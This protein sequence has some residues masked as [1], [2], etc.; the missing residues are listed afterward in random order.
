VTRAADLLAIWE[1]ARGLA[2]LRRAQLLSRFACDSKSEDAATAQ[3]I[4]STNADMLALRRALFGSELTALV[5][6]SA[7]AVPLEAEM[8][9]E[10]FIDSHRDGGGSVFELETDRGALRFRLP[11]LNDL[12]SIGTGAAPER[13][14]VALLEA[15]VVD[16][17]GPHS[18]S[19]QDLVLARMAELDPLADPTIALTCEA[20]G[21]H[22]NC[23]FDIASFLWREI[24]AAAARTFSE[25]HTL[26]SLYGWAEADLLAMSPTRR[27]A[28]LDLIG[29]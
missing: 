29:A 26:A 6:C 28:Y 9:V 7:C 5:T 2:P 15:C 13:A 17:E 11:T 8:R 18:A 10:D 21:A 24:E 12:A 22:F 19:T 1:A 20:C 3:P 16:A 25:I 14:A 23:A 4:G 27:Q